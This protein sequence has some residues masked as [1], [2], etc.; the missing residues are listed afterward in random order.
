MTDISFY[1]NMT[2]MFSYCYNLIDIDISNFYID[3]NTIIKNMFSKCQVEL[4]D[5]I[6]MQNNKIKDEVFR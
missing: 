6:K 3:D 2:H 5:K 1:S 4:K